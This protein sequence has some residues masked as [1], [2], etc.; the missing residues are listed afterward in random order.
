[1]GNWTARYITNPE[2]T[3]DG[4]TPPSF[5][6]MYGFPNGRK[7]RVMIATEKEMVAAKIPVE[8]RDYCAHKL[9]DYKQCR[10]EVWPWTYQCAHE[11][12]AYLTCQYEDYIIRMKEYEREK[13]LLRRNQNIQGHV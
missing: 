5:D 4:S 13:R 1:M 7:E 2:G 11:K 8:N 3:P 9:I 10:Q 12:H 6:P